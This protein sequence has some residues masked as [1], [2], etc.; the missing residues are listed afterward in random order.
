MFQYEVKIDHMNLLFWVKDTFYRV[1]DA[2][3]GSDAKLQR[4][5]SFIM[6]WRYIT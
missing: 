5:F 3:S 1:S 4:G 6:H 2:V